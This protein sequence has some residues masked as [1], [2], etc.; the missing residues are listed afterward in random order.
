MRAPHANLSVEAWTGVEFARIPGL[1]GNL[2]NSTTGS[3]QTAARL[4]IIDCSGMPTGSA[5]RSF[6]KA[7]SSKLADD[8]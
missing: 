2:V 3:S 6:W 8:C 7:L 5:G 1:A 4:T